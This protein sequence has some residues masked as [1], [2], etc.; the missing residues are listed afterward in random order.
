MPNEIEEWTPGMRKLWAETWEM[1]H[2]KQ[3]LRVMREILRPK[4]L[5]IAAGQDA[6]ALAAAAYHTSVGR[7]DVFDAI[8]GMGRVVVKRQDLPEP[9]SE[10]ALQGHT[11]SPSTPQ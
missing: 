8:E 6:T 10:A 5:P 11:E 3:G 2:M 9:W 1:P 4:P 7:Q